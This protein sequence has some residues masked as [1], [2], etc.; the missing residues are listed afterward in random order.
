MAIIKMIKIW[1]YINDQLIQFRSCFTREATFKWFLLVVIGLMTRSD[2]LGV[3]SIIRELMLNPD[4]YHNL[5]HFFRSE[6]W[7]LDAI[8]QEWLEIVKATGKIWRL[9]GMPI[10]IGD[11]VKEPKEATR[12]PGVKKIHQESQDSSKSEYIRGQLFGGLGILIGNAAKLFSLPLSMSIHDGN[13]AILMWKKSEYQNDSHVTRLVREACKSALAIGEKCWL[14]M[15]TYF[16]T[17]PALSAISEE[18]AKAGREPVTLVTRAK[19]NYSAWWK[20]DG[21]VAGKSAKPKIADSFKIM[22]LFRTKAE[23]FQEAILTLYGEQEKITYY[24]VDLL[25]NRELFQEIRFVLVNMDGIQSILACTDLLMDPCKI[26][27][28]YCFRFKIETFFRAFKQVLSGFA[29]HFWTRRMPVFKPFA[30]AVDMAEAVQAVTAEVARESI[31]KTYDAIEGFVFFAC[32]AMGL[33]QLCALSYSETINNNEKRWMRTN[34][35]SIPSEETTSIN[36]RCS[37]S[38]LFDNCDDLAIVKAIKERQF[39]PRAVLN[40]GDELAMSA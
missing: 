8:K 38:I 34:S 3:T 6:A 33:I 4:Q 39:E 21:Y 10:L 5:I 37:L 36:L 30:K 19:S 7:K 12:M 24:C 23:Y 13:D 15:D 16:L 26:I 35:N 22:D 25:W 40:E 17:G 2:H 32:I 27:E 31:M 29:C 14:L 9:Y 1:R 20:P 11:G 18:T 28:L